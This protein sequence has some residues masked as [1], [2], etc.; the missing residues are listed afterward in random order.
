MNPLKIVIGIDMFGDELTDKLRTD[1]PSVTFATAFEPTT[2]QQEIADADG[3]LGSP[4]ADALRAAKR[5]RWV[6]VPGM[7]IDH[8]LDIPESAAPDLLITN[9]PGT[10]TKPIADHV[11]F[12]ILALAHRARELMDDQRHKRWNALAYRA[13]M[14]DLNNT[15]MVLLG[16]GGIGRAVHQ[17]ATSFGIQ[18]SAI[19]PSPTDVPSG[20]QQ[21][22]GLEQ[23]DAVLPTAD[24]LIVTPPLTPATRN[25]IDAR[26][27]GLLKP[28]AFVIVVSRGGI[29]DED[30]LVTALRSGQVAGAGLDATATEP[31][32]PDS[33]LWDMDN[34]YISPHCSG[35]SPDLWMQRRQILED[36]V[37]R[38]VEGRPLAFVCDTQRGY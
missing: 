8:V 23:L 30:A 27:I 35:D 25:L 9:A 10:H 15:T 16:I 18:V 32:P 7:G 4:D 26:R 14:L 31:L 6:H 19:D 3:F 38:F 1:H 12:F 24:W 29:V 20:L 37:G 28:G 13:R 34:V 5:L 22:G 2:Q 17:R 21:M 11:M 36:Q 33:P